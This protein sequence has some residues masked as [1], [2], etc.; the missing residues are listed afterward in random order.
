[1]ENLI[2]AIAKGLV[3]N[4]EAVKVKRLDND[5]KKECYRLYVEKP[6]RGKII[7]RNG[8]TI[9]AFKIIVGAAAAKNGRRIS[10]EIYEESRL[11]PPMKFFKRF[12]KDK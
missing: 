7:G 11:K 1:M 2:A 12:K 10:L 5:G 4:P 6:D 9:K 8:R 3:N